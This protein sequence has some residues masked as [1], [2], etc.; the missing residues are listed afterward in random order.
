MRSAE[1]VL[2][3]KP[4][5]GNL[6]G[7]CLFQGERLLIASLRFTRELPNTE[8]AGGAAYCRQ[9]RERAHEDVHGWLWDS[10]GHGA[11][12]R[13]VP[14]HVQHDRRYPL[15]TRLV[16]GVTNTLRCSGRIASPVGVRS[17]TPTRPQAAAFPPGRP[18]RR[19]CRR[20]PPQRGG[21]PASS[22]IRQGP[23]VT[24]CYRRMRLARQCAPHFLFSS[25]LVSITLAR[26]PS[27]GAEVEMLPDGGR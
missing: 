15:Q 5:R 6:T 18:P 27:R 4:G 17:R 16:A 11:S 7:L 20:K 13:R 12:L 14:P 1:M 25:R 19:R 21:R 2:S 10:R 3:S 23:H 24:R 26:E 22:R 8:R 9:G